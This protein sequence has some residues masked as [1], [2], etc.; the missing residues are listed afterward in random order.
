MSTS[1]LSS[2]PTL[3]QKQD[4]FTLMEE[5]VQ[6]TME[7]FS[8]DHPRRRDDQDLSEELSKLSFLLDDEE[9]EEECY[10]DDETDEEDED[11]EE[12]FSFV[13]NDGALLSPIAAED[14]FRDGEIRPVFPLFN[15]DLFLAAVDGGLEDLSLKRLKQRLPATPQVY[16]EANCDPSL[17]ASSSSAGNEE[18]AGPCC[19]WSSPEKKIAAEETPAA[20]VCKKSNSTGFSKFL[21]FKEFI[22]RSNSEGRDAFVFFKPPA[23]AKGSEKKPAMENRGTDGEVKVK[24]PAEVKVKVAQKKKKKSESALAHERFLRSKANDGRGR[25]RSYLPYRPELVGLFTNVNGGLTRNV[26]PF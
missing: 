11:E 3:P 20:D 6:N 1:V 13:C 17:K 4:P 25:R 24:V 10:D 9:D 7:S 14:V 12:E 16:V 19:Q 5:E 26:H 23:P 21:R 15:R 18:I 22:H 8:F 2:Q